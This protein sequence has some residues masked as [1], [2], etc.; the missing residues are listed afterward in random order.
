MIFS[1]SKALNA[2]YFLDVTPNQF[3]YNTVNRMAYLGI[4]TGCQT[5]YY[6]PNDALQRSQ[7]AVF[8]IRA[9]FESNDNLTCFS[10]DP[11]WASCGASSPVTVCPYGLS[12]CSCQSSL[13]YFQDVQG[14]HDHFKWIQKMRNLGIT[15]GTSLNPP[16]FSPTGGVSNLVAATFAIRANQ[17][18]PCNP[19]TG[20]CFG[21][22]N[23]AF[24]DHSQPAY[25]PIDMP[26][27][28]SGFN[29]AQKIRDIGGIGIGCSER[30]FC[31]NTALNRGP[32]SYYI[33]SGMRQD[34]AAIRTV[35]QNPVGTSAW[36]PSIV[37]G[38]DPDA[39]AV[40]TSTDGGATFG[41]LKTVDTKTPGGNLIG[42]GRESR[43]VGTANR[44]HAF[45]PDFPTPSFPTPIKVHRYESSIDLNSWAYAGT[46]MD[47]PAPKLNSWNSLLSDHACVPRVNPPPPDYEACHEVFYG[48]AMDA[49]G[50]PQGNRWSVLFAVNAAG[51]NNLVL[52]TSDRG[53]GYADAA[54]RDQFMGSTAIAPDG[55]Y[56]VNYLTFT[57]PF[58]IWSKYASNVFAKALRFPPGG[59]RLGA[60]VSEGVAPVSWKGVP[61][62]GRCVEGACYGSGDYAKIAADYGETVGIPHIQQAP[63]ALLKNAL[64]GIFTREVSEAF[65][66]PYDPAE[67]A[68]SAGHASAETKD[69]LRT[70][71][72]LIVSAPPLT[73]EPLPQEPPRD[74]PG[75]RFAPNWVPIALGS[76][77]PLTGA[78]IPPEQT[79]VTRQHRWGQLRAA[80]LAR[81]GDAS[82]GE[83][84]K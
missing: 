19:T 3:F 67:S 76:R 11:A 14:T 27:G 43:I 46:L 28:T 58:S 64:Y 15:C 59:A 4:T 13:P 82:R 24:T 37:R 57:R 65:Y 45:V 51:N 73:V 84:P 79:R 55:S 44:F 72:P 74:H 49:A 31:P 53:C 47:F 66:A 48:N 30:S 75:R 68:E 12:S 9:L 34:F 10:P 70:A 77:I 20:F 54:P 23:N 50:D 81:M 26:S 32:A 41:S 52:C 2:Q 56:W 35:S 38:A 1:L 6:C 60:T 80:L 8:A 36:E 18:K 25:F 22:I 78:P 17:L 83:E 39:F 40:V 61:G 16:L 29:F 71:V 62:A 7:M 69:L 33:T 5:N 21:G 42:G 63:G